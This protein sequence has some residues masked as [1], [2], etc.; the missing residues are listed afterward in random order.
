MS[1]S[2]AAACAVSH[3]ER[4]RDAGLPLTPTTLHLASLLVRL[5]GEATLSA[6]SSTEPFIER[7]YARTL[8]RWLAARLEVG[9]RVWTRP[10]ILPVEPEPDPEPAPEMTVYD[11]I[12]LSKSIIGDLKRSP[13]WSSRSAR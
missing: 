3:L 13:I 10:G 6:T 5:E 12:Q 8:A 11:L 9:R 7:A 2:E 4:Q 1:L